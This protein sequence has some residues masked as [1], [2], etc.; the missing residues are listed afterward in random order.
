MYSINCLTKWYK[1]W[2]KN[3]WK[4]AQNKPVLNKEIIQEI[5]KYTKVYINIKFIHVPAHKTKPTDKSKINAWYG[6]KMADELA[7]NAIL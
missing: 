1:N 3:N 7:V 4:T 2:E 6:N 5:L